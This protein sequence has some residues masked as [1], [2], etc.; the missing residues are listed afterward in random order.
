[1]RKKEQEYKTS[2]L[3]KNIKDHI[4]NTKLCKR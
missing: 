1:M 3:A 2:L 4:K